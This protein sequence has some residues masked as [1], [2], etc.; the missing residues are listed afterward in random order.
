MRFT[1]LICSVETW[2]EKESILDNDILLSNR[3]CVRHDRNRNGGGILLFIK[4]NY[5]YKTLVKT[6]SC[7]L[8][9]VQGPTIGVFIDHHQPQ[10]QLWIL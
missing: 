1:A 2:L 10:S 3:V 5:Q 9:V 8:S 6:L 4:S 7:F